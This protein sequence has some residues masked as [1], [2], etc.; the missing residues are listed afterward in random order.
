MSAIKLRVFTAVAGVLLGLGAFA[1]ACQALIVALVNWLG[2]VGGLAAAA[3]LLAALSFLRSGLC[4][5]RVKRSTR[6]PKR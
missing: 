3:G 6:K 1:L 2:P 4:P 5:G